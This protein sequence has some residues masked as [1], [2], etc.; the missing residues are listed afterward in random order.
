MIEKLNQ[1]SLAHYEAE[2]IALRRKR[3]PISYAKIA[4]LLKEKYQ[5]S[6]CREA[7]FYFIKR[8][9]EKKY[10]P[11][12]YDAWDIELPIDINMQT[13]E[14]SREQNVTV[15]KSLVANN[16]K[17]AIESK[18]FEMQYSNNYN[19]HRL[20][21]EVAEAELKQLELEERN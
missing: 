10:K 3:P 5:V 13:T 4:E 2:I 12:K 1:S 9:V 19:L 17:P 6:V 15:P 16:P 7:I 18:V 20:T 21:D 11:C 8:R 14:I